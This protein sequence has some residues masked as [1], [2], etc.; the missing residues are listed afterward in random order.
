MYWYVLMHIQTH[1]HTHFFYEIY[2]PNACAQEPH[3][4]GHFFRFNIYHILQESRRYSKPKMAAMLSNKSI[5]QLHLFL[6]PWRHGMT[7]KAG[8]RCAGGHG[9][10]TTLKRLLVEE[11]CIYLLNNLYSFYCSH[12]FYR[13]SS[14]YSTQDPLKDSIV[15]SLNRVMFY[16]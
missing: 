6:A 13:C 3:G 7:Q 5:V 15:R 4:F 12:D 2:G 10:S 9:I 11:T 14:G 16:L 1:T 8:W